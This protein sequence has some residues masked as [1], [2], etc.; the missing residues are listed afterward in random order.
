MLALGCAVLPACSDDDSGGTTKPP[1][2]RGG[3][4]DLSAEEQ[5]IVDA[6]QAWIDDEAELDDRP[7]GLSSS[8]PSWRRTPNVTN[9]TF[10]QFIDDHRVVGGELVVHVLEDGTVQGANN[11]LI[12]AEPAGEDVD[13]IDEAEAEE[14][15]V[16]GG[17]GHARGDRAHR[18]GL[19]AVG[20]RPAA[21]LRRSTSPPTDPDGTSGSLVNAETGDVITP[22]TP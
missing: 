6:A 21:G 11:A 19:G 22:P 16:Q 7:E 15:A 17:R 13:P 1:P 2:V 3:A 10:T 8:S 18:A 14:N 5:E 9:V 12:D 4:E 20:Q